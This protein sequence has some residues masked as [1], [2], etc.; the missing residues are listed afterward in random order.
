MKI[1]VFIF[2]T[3][4]ALK[5]GNTNYL[6]EVNMTK[7]DNNIKSTTSAHAGTGM[8]RVIEKKR[9]NKKL[10][11]F[12]AAGLIT[13]TVIYMIFDSVSGGRT[14]RVEESR[15]V[16]ST[17]T[18]GVYEDYIPIRGKVTPL[19]TVFVSATEG[20]RVER[21]LVEDGAIVN[22]GQ[23]IVEL[24][25]PTLQLEVFQ[26]EAR[27]AGQLN[28]MRTLELQLEQNRLRHITNITTLEY[29]IQQM[30]RNIERYR[31]LYANGNYTKAQMDLAEEDLAYKI[32]MLDITKQS[33]E[34]DA[35]MQETQL[36]MSKLDTEN[37]ERN[38]GIARTSLENLNM[39]A[40]IEGQLS[41]FDLELGQTVSP[42]TAIG[43]IDDP[44]NFKLEVQVDEFYLN[45][46]DLG[47]NGVYV[48][49]GDNAEFPMRIK[50]IYPDVQNNQFKID[51]VFTEEQPE[52]IRRGQTLQSKLTLGDSAEAVLI[53]NGAFY[54]DTG[55]SWVFVVTD[56]S[57]TAIKRNVRL[58][59]KNNNYIEVIEGLEIGERVIT[60]PYT[61][62]MD[63]DRLKLTEE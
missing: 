44:Y 1:N 10:A 16:V 37:L 4:F 62:F 23:A 19:T 26:N 30:T 18:S 34:T 29:E 55:G 32:K 53:P 57:T 12:G 25:N 27:V 33:Q 54:Q 17:V 38:L 15:L 2:G 14:F 48:R 6:I 46:I 3:L 63:M 52:D 60:S 56:D 40:Q 9:D 43:Q 58:G 5:E 36:Q 7:M 50:K 51:M 21:I 41:G 31:R 22:Q 61:S 49:P 8:D 35:R 20:G 13:L 47:Q 11:L 59:R 45:R 39:K 24:S 42:G 28:A